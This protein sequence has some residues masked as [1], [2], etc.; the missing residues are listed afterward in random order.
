MSKLRSPISLFSHLSVKL[1]EFS[2]LLPTTFRQRSGAGLEEPFPALDLI[3]KLYDAV[4]HELLAPDYDEKTQGLLKQIR[5]DIHRMVS[6][7][8]SA[9]AVCLAPNLI[10]FEA[11]ISGPQENLYRS[12]QLLISFVRSQFNPL[13][14]AMILEAEKEAGRPMA[15]CITPYKPWD[16]P[17]L[18]SES[19]RE[20][21]RCLEEPPQRAELKCAV[22]QCGIP[23]KERWP[24]CCP[25]ATAAISKQM[26]ENY[27]RQ[28]N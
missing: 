12:A 18:S 23:N 25:E 4:W 26:Y 14:D 16:T 11:S 3:Q 15:I 2:K 17:N 5:A 28:K 24:R 9:V 21:S 10:G 22:H 20:I 27:I 13:L 19:F 6:T 8:K 1:G 7:T